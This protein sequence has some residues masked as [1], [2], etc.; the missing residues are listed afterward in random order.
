MLSR[1]EFSLRLRPDAILHFGH[2][3]L[4]APFNLTLNIPE[5][6]GPTAPDVGSFVTRPSRH[7]D[8]DSL[9]FE[10][11]VYAEMEMTPNARTRV[12]TGVRAD[13]EA[14]MRRF[15]VSPRMNARYDV[16]HGFPR[17]TLKGGTG[18]FSQPPDLGV[19]SMAA[20]AK[21]LHFQRSWQSSLGLE[22]ELSRQVEASVE[23]FLY[24]MD[25]LVSQDANAAGV[26]TYN[27]FGTGRTF[28]GEALLRY[29]ADEDFF[30]W[31][32]YTLSRSERTWVP[33]EPSQLFGLD[34][35]HILTILGSYTL[36]KGWEVGARFRYA[37]GNLHTPCLGGILSTT[38]GGYLCIPAETNSARLGPF[39][40]LDI[41]VDKRFQFSGWELGAYLDL[42][43][44]YNRS[45]PDFVAYNYDYSRSRTQSASLPIVPSIGIR[46]EF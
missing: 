3:I 31:V 16:V 29:K 45:N 42:I 1:S 18:L 7:V 11:A 40:Q 38:S 35:T 23:G 14:K 27:N 15:D 6:P 2:D 12:V 33:G 17:T 8:E 21:R 26:L 5:D 32:S 24:L 10:P 4:F 39:H 25:D 9:F 34:Q 30:G 19:L 22:Q 28:G 36:G 41:R 20:D 44:A 13:Y 37:S 43:N 46:G